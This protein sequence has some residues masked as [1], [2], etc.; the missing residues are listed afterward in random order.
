MQ[1]GN[2]QS[3]YDIWSQAIEDTIKKVENNTKKRDIR[4]DVKELIKMR[5]ELRKKLQEETNY[6]NKKQIIERIKIIKEH[7]IDKQ[8]ESR[9]N[10]IHKI[11]DSIKHQKGKLKR[12]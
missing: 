10:K 6:Y 12:E 9:G 2:L 8:K 4:K 5:K 3:Q 11:A 1:T 7:I